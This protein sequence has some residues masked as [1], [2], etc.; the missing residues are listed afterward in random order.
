MTMLKFQAQRLKIK[1]ESITMLIS[2]LPMVMAPASL[3]AALLAATLIRAAVRLTGKPVKIMA[4]GV[5]SALTA[6]TVIMK[7][8]S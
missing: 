1:M 2:E 7:Y 5:M 3:I 6:G 8:L 4:V